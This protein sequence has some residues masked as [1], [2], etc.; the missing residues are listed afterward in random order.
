MSDADL[1]SFEAWLEQN[2]SYTNTTP[3]NIGAGRGLG[4]TAQVSCDSY[5]FSFCHKMAFTLLTVLTRNC[6]HTCSTR[7]YVQVLHVCTQFLVSTVS[8][9]NASL[10]QK[11]NS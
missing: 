9:V 2:N 4:G 8:S 5:E 11:E 6:V 7:M 1:K 3:T 10:W